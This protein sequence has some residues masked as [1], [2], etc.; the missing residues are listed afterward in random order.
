MSALS[1]TGKIVDFPAAYYNNGCHFTF[2]DGH[3][4]IHKWRSREFTQ[5]V[6]RGAEL[7]LNVD[8]SNNPDLQWMR[9][10]ATIK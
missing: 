3:S 7:T 5:S 2:A 9:S 10:K 8:T 1:G 4:E 6:R